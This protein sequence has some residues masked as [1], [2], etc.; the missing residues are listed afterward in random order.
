MSRKRDTLESLDQAI[1]RIAAADVAE[2]VGEAHIEARAK[3]R[4]ILAEAMAE[5]LLDLA[6]AQL[7]GESP[8][9]NRGHERPLTTPAESER[10]ASEP[11]G[12]GYYVYGVVDVDAELPH[13]VIGIDDA[14]QVVL[15]R[16]ESIAAVASPVTLAEFGE[17]ALEERLED[18]GWLEHRARRHEQ[19]LE[20]VRERTPLVPMRLCSIY[21]D[22]RSVR[23]MLAREH[24]FLADALRRLADRTEWGA[25]I[26]AVCDRA[27]EAENA[28]AGETVGGRRE[29][30]EGV[31]AAGSAAAG[32]ERGPGASY[33][34]ARQMQGRRREG[35]QAAVQERC[36]RAHAE[37]A[38]TAVEAKLNPVQPREL[39]G[40]EE[41][42]ILNGV[43]LVEDAATDEFVSVLGDLRAEL[44]ADG[45]ELE[46]T[47]PWSPYN[48]VNSPTEVGR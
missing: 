21:R 14:H 2:L 32:A 42:M 19:V 9:A 37:L 16:G 5:R 48:F 1:D 43:Y 33:L 29:A 8:Q 41:P 38:R 31:G 26:Y 12:L 15:V 6:E 10:E 22:E 30:E 4:A 17:Q 28:A 18:L 35:I 3:V 45:L 11:Q 46:L 24:A 44:A 34:V 27:A 20:R 40:R 47:G 13:G 36:E 23:E 25:K 7:R 39:S